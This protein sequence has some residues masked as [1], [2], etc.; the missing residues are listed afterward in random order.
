[1]RKNT[2]RAYLWLA[3][4]LFLLLS[5]PKKVEKT[6]RSFAQ[7][8]LIP[9]WEVVS[10]LKCFLATAT[11]PTARESSSSA[12]L[13]RLRQENIRL[14]EHIEG[15]K[16]WLL[17]EERLEQQVER[18][19]ALHSLNLQE[20]EPY[21]KA[22]FQRRSVH[23]AK[24]IYAQ[25]QALPAKV[26]FREPVSWSSFLWL[27]VGEA[28]NEALGKTVVSKNSPVVLGESIVGVVEN[29]ERHR[30]L[31]RLITDAQ[32]V[33][34]VRAVRE[35]PPGA[36]F[37]A[38]GELKGSAEVAFRQKSTLLKG[39]GFNCDFA[40]EEG[41]ARDLRTPGLIQPG[42]LLITTGMDG[43]FP[44]GFSVAVVT[45]VKPLREGSAAYELLAEMTAG[46]LDE[47]KQLFVLPPA[48]LDIPK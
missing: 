19:K 12:E 47:V 32:L 33:P 13:L 40:D 46:S 2:Y 5:A 41:P 42:D 3:L 18:L 31:V 35:R 44:Q 45:E 37:L 10:Y 14:R 48:A 6:V 9:T 11:T 4:L 17:F 7:S 25:L 1:M 28:D 27:D 16:G 22:F 21:W 23:L 29:V 34:S 24:R 39:A 8:T 20:K 30:C 36:L 26:V 15:M 43:V 38:K